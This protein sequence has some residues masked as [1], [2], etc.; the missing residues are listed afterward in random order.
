MSDLRSQLTGIYQ[1][2]GELTP[3]I[4]VDEAR[5]LD[6]P[7]HDRFEWDDEIAGEKYRLVQGSRMIRVVRMEITITDSEEP[8]FI[9][10]FHSLHESGDEERKGY[11]PT[12]EILENE[13]TRK[14]L[15][16]NMEREIS[17][18]KK[19]Y[20]HLV[21]FAETMRRVIGDEGAA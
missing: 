21:E 17:Q 7:L 2:H 9:R 20:G 1:K 14:I 4:V 16:R 3:Q 6:A 12:E 13:M 11:A 8:T 5:P 18:L 15:L 10:A 19:R